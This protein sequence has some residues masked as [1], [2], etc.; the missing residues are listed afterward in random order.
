ML[1]FIQKNATLRTLPFNKGNYNAC[2]RFQVQVYALKYYFY[3]CTRLKSQAHLF[4]M[5][6]YL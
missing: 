4:N 1:N 5:I 6:F 2:S 3:A